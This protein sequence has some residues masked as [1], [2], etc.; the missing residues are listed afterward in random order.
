MLLLNIKHPS[1][2]NHICIQSYLPDFAP[3]EFSSGNGKRILTAVV[4]KEQM[5]HAIKQ[6]I[7]SPKYIKNGPSD[8]AMLCRQLLQRTLI[9]RA[10][11]EKGLSDVC[12]KCRFKL[13]CAVRTG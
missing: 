3:P 5:M 10:T 7:P 9:R 2:E 1:Y 8:I 4:F 6:L 11:R 12:V 13:A